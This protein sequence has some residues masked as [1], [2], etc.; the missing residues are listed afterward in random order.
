MFLQN[1]ACTPGGNRIDSL[2]CNT[3][4][5]CAV[6]QH[7][8]RDIWLAAYSNAEHDFLVGTACCW[9]PQLSEWLSITQ[10]AYPILVHG[11]TTDFNP[12]C[13]GGDVHHFIFQND[14]LI[15]HPSAFQHA[16]FSTLENIPSL[17]TRLEGP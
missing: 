16:K 12:S 10:K 11:M 9:V 8:S 4:C 13:D 3:P 14:H 7:H 1:Q 2:E 15:T 17:H 6:G 5:I